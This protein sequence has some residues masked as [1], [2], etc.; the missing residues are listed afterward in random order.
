MN[1]IVAGLIAGLGAFI[2]DWVLWGKVFTKGMEQL[3]TPLSPEQMKRLM[4]ANIPKSAGLAFA[5]GILLAFLYKR[6]AP[7]L[8]VSGGGAL[9]GMELATILWLP[10]IALATLGSSVWYDKARPLLWGMFWAW[11]IRMNVAGALVGLLA[12]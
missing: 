3:A 9:A 4:G 7:A 6:F 12:R 11:L 10:T 1:W 2:A 8:W 5:F